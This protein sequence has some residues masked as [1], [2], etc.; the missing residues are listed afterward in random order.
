MWG[1][2]PLDVG[3]FIDGEH[4]RV[5][6]HRVFPINGCHRTFWRN[7]TKLSSYDVCETLTSNGKEVDIAIDT[8]IFRAWVHLF[9]C[10]FC[11]PVG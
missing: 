7:S 9:F 3:I 2:S 6:N 11:R 10:F 4:K 8:I 1:N 5:K